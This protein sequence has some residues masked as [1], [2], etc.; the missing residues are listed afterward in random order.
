VP[1][2]DSPDRTVETVTAEI[3]RIVIERQRLRGAAA[4]AVVLEQNRRL[5]AAAQ[6]QLSR[7]LIERHLGEAAA[8]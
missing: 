5:L 1:P 3:G 8:G 4:D 7:L 6:S 2:V